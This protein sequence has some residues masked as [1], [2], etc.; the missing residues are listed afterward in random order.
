MPDVGKFLQKGHVLATSFLANLAFPTWDNADDFLGMKVLHYDKYLLYKT[1]ENTCIYFH[2]ESGAP[3]YH[4]SLPSYKASGIYETKLPWSLHCNFML[5][6]WV[7]K[8]GQIWSGNKMA[9]SF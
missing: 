7:A 5:D 8:C 4:P 3:S 2:N 9:A 6:L 1:R